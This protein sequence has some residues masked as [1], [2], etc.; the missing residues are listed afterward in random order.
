[1]DRN[2]VKETRKRKNMSQLQLSYK[3][4]IAPGTISNIENHKVY[5]YDGWKKRISEALEVPENELFPK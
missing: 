4:K 1:M 5:A 2:Y 3:T